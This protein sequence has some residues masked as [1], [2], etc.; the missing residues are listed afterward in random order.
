VPPEQHAPA[1]AT[2]NATTAALRVGVVQWR[3]TLDVGANLELAQ[4][5]I[6]AGGEQGAD[7]VLLPENGLC[8]GSNA[9]MRDAAIWV[10]GPEI[11]ALR[12][13][14]RAAHTCVV[15]GGV[16]TRDADG[17]VYNTAHII[18]ASGELVGGYDKIHLF[19][20]NVGGQLFAASSVERRGDTPTLLELRGVRIGITICYDVRFPELYRQLALHGAEV[21][22]VP[23]AFTYVTGRAHWEVLLRARAIENAAWVVASATVHGPEGDAF[24]TWGHSLVVDPWGTVAVDL[25]EVEYDCRV[26]EL[27]RSRVTDARARLPALRHVRPDAYSRAPRVLRVE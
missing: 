24:A 11:G 19:D 1:T 15:L 10:D 22:L 14:A 17:G 20:A 27:D 7:L 13:A 26:V 5:A 3:A 2:G 6:A 4:R 21:L 25:G 9:Q 18:D 8:L 12:E 23:S 16:K